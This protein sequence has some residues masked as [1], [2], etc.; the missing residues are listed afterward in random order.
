MGQVLD[1]LKAGNGDRRKKEIQEVAMKNYDEFKD[2]WPGGSPATEGD[3]YEL[4][5]VTIEK[6]NKKYGYARIKVPNRSDLQKLFE[7]KHVNGQNLGKEQFQ[8]ILQKVI[9]RASLSGVGPMFIYL[10]GI[11]AGAFL[12]RQ[13][14]FPNFLS[15]DIY[16]MATTSATA[17]A[18]AHLNKI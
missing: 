1:M 15:D 18:L 11:P 6:I 8:E 14:A 2:K 5:Y 7:D 17:L 12:L 13:R 3:F 9:L 10:L 16:I 4:V